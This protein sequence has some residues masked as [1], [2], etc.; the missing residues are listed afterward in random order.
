MAQSPERDRNRNKIR[1]KISVRDIS[2][3]PLLLF[4]YLVSALSLYIL[5]PE[6]SPA[7]QTLLKWPLVISGLMAMIAKLVARFGRLTI[8]VEEVPPPA[9]SEAPGR[10]PL[11]F[12]VPTDEQWY[13][14]TSEGRMGPYTQERIGEFIRKDGVGR[15]QDLNRVV[16]HAE[17]RERLASIT[18]PAEDFSIFDGVFRA[19]DFAERRE[20][21]RRESE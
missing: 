12:D 4:G 21:Q 19:R 13:I 14:V 3:G 10:I 17:T 20:Q 6:G 7:S 5:S 1:S 18:Q 16:L 8:T 11:S 15:Q 2:V 9:Q